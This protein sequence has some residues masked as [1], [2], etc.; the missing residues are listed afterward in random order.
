MA[1][2]Q[3]IGR[4]RKG[5]RVKGKLKAA[6]YNEAVLKMK[7]KG[8]AIRSLTEL[9]GILYR[10]INVIKPNIKHKDLVIY[11]RQFS[12][13]I[14]AGI[15]VVDSTKILAE[16]TVNRVLKQT[17]YNIYEDIQTGKSYTEAAEK[18]PTIFPSMFI[19]MMKAGEA[20]G[21]IEEILERMAVYFEKQHQ[22][23][24][25]IKAAM[26][27]PIILAIISIA[28]VIFML[29]VIVPKFAGMF[30]SFNAK[31]PAL[32][33]WLLNSS[34]FVVH[35][36]WLFILF[37]LLLLLGY[38]LLER[39]KNGSF[40]LDMIKLKIPVFGK[41]I[42]KAALARMTRTLSTLF[43][44]SVP[45]L[46]AISIVENVVGNQVIAKILGES[47]NYI[48]EGKSIAE[49]MKDHW[50]IP[51][52]VSQM[53]II[54]EQSGTIDYMLEKV[55]EFYESEVD[56]ATE[57]LKSLLEPMMIVFLAGVVGTIV[58]AITIPMYSVFQN[59]Q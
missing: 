46:H 42:Q 54:G 29:A 10:E 5:E 47:K 28:V 35:Y 43:A 24:Q 56:Q 3:Y 13:L 19:N 2:F 12:T 18:F 53:M 15:S 33:L 4:N 44:S 36:F 1:V 51:P 23:R 55:A 40:Y 49:P 45:I 21:Q 9:K 17:L 34:Q 59:I 37:L 25:K 22:T 50:A 52:L 20:S 6:N 14:K 57:Q 41:I 31:L 58:A 7:E 30:A 38:Y 11:I 32:T 48:E 16:Q 26:S 39:S 8:I 27:Y